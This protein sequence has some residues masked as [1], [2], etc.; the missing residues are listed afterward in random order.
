[1]ASVEPKLNALLDALHDARPLPPPIPWAT[2]EEMVGASDPKL[3]VGQV[4][5]RLKMLEK[6][7]KVEHMRGPRRGNGTG[8]AHYYRLK[9]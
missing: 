8:V 4:R 9:M 3:S 6:Q 7:G 2:V 1:M 5:T